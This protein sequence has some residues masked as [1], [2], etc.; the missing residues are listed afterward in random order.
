MKIQT[1]L[2][3]LDWGETAESTAGLAVELAIALKASVKALYVE[4][5]ELIR[6]AEQALR[7][8]PSTGTIPMEAP[9]VPMLEAEFQSEERVLGHRFLQLV[10]DTRIRGS[11][12]V[13]QGSV[14]QILIQESR[15]HDLLVMGKYS[16]AASESA[17]RRPLGRHVERIL[18][19]AWCPV[20]LVPPGATLGPKILV[21]YDDTE[22]SHRVLSTA[23][24]LA[25]RLP[26]ELRVI[27]VGAA[28]A[29]GRLLDRAGAY[30]ESHQVEGDLIAVEGSA[31]DAILRE[32]EDWE[33][34]LLAMG[35]FGPAR[36][37]ESFGV[38]ATL[39]VL[40][41]LPCA[42]LLCGSMD[43]D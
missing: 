27:A 17:P 41:A 42:A 32:A 31:A 43:E 3:G 37:R 25:Q 36:R 34:D 8:L 6:A 29:A 40:E 24:G 35:A 15:A 10:A 26:A 1:I 14:D 23:L 16:E 11:F 20:A 38:R 33:A 9:N 39:D 4:D 30:L 12:L 5:A 18:R 2:V 19:R 13:A 7:I 21:A 22:A 28:E